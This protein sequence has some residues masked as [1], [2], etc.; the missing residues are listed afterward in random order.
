M[1]CTF[2]GKIS[3]LDPGH[4]YDYCGVS[5]GGE[6]TGYFPFYMSAALAYICSFTGLTKE[7]ADDYPDLVP[8]YLTLINEMHSNR[9]YTVEQAAENPM[10]KQILALHSRNY[11]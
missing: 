11:L 5:G 6:E 1:A 3:Q 4:V 7:Q 10:V 8:V 9:D 2:A